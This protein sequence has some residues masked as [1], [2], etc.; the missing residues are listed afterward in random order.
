MRNVELAAEDLRNYLDSLSEY[1]WIRD[2]NVVTLNL[3]DITG[4]EFVTQY[5]PITLWTNFSVGEN[6]IHLL[7]G[8]LFGAIWRTTRIPPKKK[9]KYE[10]YHTLLLR[11]HSVANVLIEDVVTQDLITLFPYN[12]GEM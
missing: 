7:P 5:M 3:D 12:Y 1:K 2:Y 8:A 4:P 6:E 10:D 11:C 9:I